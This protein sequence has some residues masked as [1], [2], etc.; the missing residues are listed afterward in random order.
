MSSLAILG[1]GTWGS[2]LA[3]LFRRQGNQVCLWS[4]RKE[5]LEEIEKRGCHKNLSAALFP[6][7]IEFQPDISKAISKKDIIIF[8]V[9][10]I[11]I[12]ETAEKVRLAFDK[13]PD[14]SGK[15]DRPIIVSVAKGIE[16][17]SLMVMTD[18]IQDELEKSG[19]KYS[20]VALSGPT[21]AEEVAMGLPCGMVA[22]SK[23]RKACDLVQ[24]ELMGPSMRIYTSDDPLGVELCGAMKNIMALAAG[25]SDGLGL[26]D[27]AR[28]T[29]IT[30]GMAEIKR[31]GLAMGCPESSFYGLA[32][33]G[34]LIV[35]ATSTL[36]R[37]HKAGYF[38][39][40]GKST[41]EA[42]N[43]VGQVVEGINALPAAMKLKEKYGVD[44]PIVDVVQEVIKGRS[45]IRE[46]VTGLMTRTPKK[47]AR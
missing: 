5:G 16:K 24:K 35:T 12:R 14:V 39:G 47:E 10:S 21:H 30:R 25:A 6:S 20:Y 33:I 2:A 11:A 1:A 13:D 40:Q 19:K 26:G 22:A 46:A 31:L 36:S 15:Q 41:K 18:L 27:N 34:D 8:A 17:D 38:L 7:G 29:L 44:M 43:E 45:S 37:N 23:D 42:L 32:G 28:A 3:M 4:H 9:P